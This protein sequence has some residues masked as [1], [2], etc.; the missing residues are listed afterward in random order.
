MAVEESPKS[1]ALLTV[2]VVKEKEEDST[3]AVTVGA[4]C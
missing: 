4:N 3:R 2:A 1:G